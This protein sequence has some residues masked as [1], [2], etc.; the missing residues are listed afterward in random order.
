LKEANF[1]EKFNAK[2]HCLKMAQNGRDSVQETQPL[3][4]GESAEDAEGEV[5]A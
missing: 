5:I 2:W 3:A 1:V 4:C